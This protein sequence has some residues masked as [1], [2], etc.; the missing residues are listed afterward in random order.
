[1]A[2][3]KNVILDVDTG[4]D[5]AVA[6]LLAALSPAID[7]VAITVTHGNQPLDLTV[8]NTLR[9]V[10]H[11]DADIPVF[12]G[13]PAPMVRD[14]SPG[15]GYNVRRQTTSRTMN[16]EEVGI[17]EKHLPLPPPTRTA[18]PRHA[19]AYLVETLRAAPD[20]VTI[21]AVAP[22]TNIGMALRMDPS[23]AEAIEEII[24][25][26]GGV[27]H[28]N[29]TPV[30]EANFYDDPEAAHIVVSSGC[31]VVIMTLEATEDPEFTADDVAGFRGRSATG[32]FVADLLESYLA[33][34]RLLGIVPEGGGVSLHD[35]VAACAVI[36][37]SVITRLE[38]RNCDVDFAGGFADGQLVVDARGFV[39]PAGNVYVACA[40]DAEKCRRLIRE[41]LLGT[42]GP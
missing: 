20:P 2:M 36:E 25:M 13:C 18:D 30:A 10:E 41:T 6:I 17:H 26:G 9:V 29:R 32:D 27:H 37:P 3:G 15:R 21:L 35:A 38:Q 19:C 8:D 23:I 22:L 11:V 16:G 24:V 4:T 12:A 39:R 33:R 34:C 5:D 28:G 14:L 7:P 31:R 42:G 40:V 1:M